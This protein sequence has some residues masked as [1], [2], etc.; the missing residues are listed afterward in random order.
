MTELTDEQARIEI[1][2][3]TNETLFVEAG[4]GTGKTTALV[5]RIL[6]LIAEGVPVSEIAAITFTEKAAAELSER[7]R[8]QLEKAEKAERD[9]VLRQRIVEALD[10]LDSAAIQTLHSFAMRILSLYPLE[11]GLP[12]RLSLRD[13]VQA[14]LAF[15]ERWNRFRDELLESPELERALLRGLTVGLRLRDLQDVADIF[16]ENWERV[17]EMELPASDE[18]VL[19][20]IRIYQPV[21]EVM[22]MRRQGVSD[23]LTRKLDAIESFINSLPAVAQRVATANLSADRET[24]EVDFLRLLSRMPPITTSTTGVSRGG[25][26]GAKSNWDDVEAAREGMREAEAA[27]TSILDGTRS[28]VLCQLLPKVRD[29]VI[30]AAAERRA[31]GELEFHDLLVLARNLLRDNDEVRMALHRRFRKVLIDE[32]Q[33]TDPIQVELAALLASGTPAKDWRS[34]V[35]EPG[36]LFFVGDPKQSIYR[37][38]RADIELFKQARGSFSA[39]RLTLRKNFRCRPAIIEWVNQA[40]GH[41]FE[42]FGIDQRQADWIALEPGRDAGKS[43]AVQLLG[44]PVPT[45]KNGLRASDVRRMEAE[46]IAATVLA[47]A[48]ENWLG[49]DDRKVKETC[50]SDIAILLPTR[51]NSP[52]IEAALARADVPTRIESRSLLFAAQEIRDLTN[53]L[54]AIDD[55]TDDVAVVAALRSPAFAV[56]DGDLLE[57]SLAGGDWDYTRPVPPESPEA[58]RSGMESLNRFHA[59]RW[60]SSIGALVESVIAGRKMLELSVASSRPRESWRRLRFVAEQARS[61]GDS[62]TV[63]SLRQFV[64][65]LRTQAEE[66]VLIA[67]SVANE[68]DD[69]AVKI[70][71]VHAAK[72]LEFPIVI[73]AGLGIEPRFSAPRVAWSKD[74]AGT[75][76]V[77]VRIGREN[78]YF[79][80]PGYDEH[81]QVER[82]HSW[83]ERDR[84]FYVATTRAKERLVVSLYHAAQKEHPKRHTERKCS[85]AEC[86]DAI[87]PAY[88][89]W[90][91]LQPGLA[92]GG[93]VTA[94]I[95]EDQTEADRVAWIA[96]RAERIE[97]LGRAP[98]LAAT[99]IAHGEDEPDEEAEPEPYI[100]DQPWRKGRAGT[101]VGRAVHAVLQTIDLATGAGLRETART[102]AVAEGIADEADHIARLVESCRTSDAVRAALA[103]GKLYRELYVGTDIEGTVIEGFIDLL[104]ESPEGLVVVDYKTD[105]VRDSAQIA[106]AM[107]RYRLQG[108]AYAIVLEEALKRPVAKCVF[109]FAEPRTEVAIDDLAGAKAAV[110]ETIRGKFIPA[111]G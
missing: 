70:L 76:S 85:V 12:P 105:S 101:S 95:A 90:R 81:R 20:P 77:A 30:A 60:S 110:R 35:A 10:G 8:M 15:R 68:P 98:V 89:E 54:A 71:T 37:F 38:R 2:T 53:I 51:T 29:F 63:T 26:I 39:R 99:T 49:I 19:D 24:A 58:V 4:A 3:A 107:E 94:G 88:P 111:G 96:E 80:T 106:V 72:G 104:Y 66:R 103:A 44:G 61:L 14:T 93:G 22:G 73:L 31:A 7:V 41:L 46:A 83:L 65:W 57:H 79:D 25:N 9:P 59:S 86:L 33:D 108:A 87:R 13:D 34:A 52:A 92:I 67:E 91:T 64:H 21:A 11:A 62:G 84:L 40:S 50:F 45:G 78:S 74:D 27:R 48:R 55:P 16:N 42:K 82:E 17:E 69:D 43:P 97:R 18:P 5:S 47:A 32:F 100:D 75:E 1:R 36:R 109:V 56:K 28:W 102:Q 23:G 6:A